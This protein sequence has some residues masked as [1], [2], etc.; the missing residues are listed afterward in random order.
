MASK[1]KRGAT[2]DSGRKKQGSIT[3]E[4]KKKII[5]KYE[6]GVRVSQLA[7]EYGRS[8]STICT[9]LKKREEIKK[10]DVAKGVKTMHS[11]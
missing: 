7:T 6:K 10:L 3:I 4:D 9:I 1:R 11:N 5:G 8:T 2:E